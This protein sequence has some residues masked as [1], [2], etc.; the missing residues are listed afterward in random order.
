M[1]FVEY[2]RSGTE[3]AASLGEGLFKGFRTLSQQAK[4]DFQRS[5]WK[6]V[7][8]ICWDKYTVCSMNDEEVVSVPAP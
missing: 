8:S 4:T 1:I 7:L 6:S 5:R 2:W 3:R